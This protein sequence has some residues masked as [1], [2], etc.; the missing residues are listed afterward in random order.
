MSVAIVGAGLAGLSAA[1]VLTEAGRAVTLFDKSRGVGGRMSTR[2]AGDYEFDHG[3]QYFT[4][5]DP[6]FRSLVERLAADG[7]AARWDSRGL[8]LRSGALEADTGRPRWVGTPRMNSLPKA[9]AD[10]L[11]TRLGTRIAAVVR[12]DDGYRLADETGET[13]G[14]FEDV[15][16]TV[17]APQAAALLP[18]HAPVQATLASVSMHA[19]FALMV[20]F[21]ADGTAFDPGW[22]SLRVADLPVS[23]IAVNSAKP[24]RPEGATTLMI[25]GAP[26]WSDRHA[27]HDRDA[28]RDTL[29]TCA[30]ALCGVALDKAPH[31]ALHRWLYAYADEGVGETVLRD[32]QTGVWMAGDW[33]VGGRV[34]GAWTSGRDAGRAIAE[35]RD[36]TDR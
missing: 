29:L 13:F 32:P 8:Y 22:D 12:D 6:D 24:G 33:L 34:E 10:G 20:G 21:P 25:H 9:L 31:I 27:Q 3:A 17:P 30:S 2:Y 11:D 15:L 28:V 36:P 18:E 4:V 19:C 26:G 7:H 5:S 23:W 35:A 1:R 14:P 16:L